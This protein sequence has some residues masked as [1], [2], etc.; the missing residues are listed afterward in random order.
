MYKAEFSIRVR[1]SETDRM[2][3]VYYGKYAEYFEVARVECLRS[4]GI[5]YKELEEDGVL[6]PVR[7]YKIRFFKPGFYDDV[8]R[9]ETIIPELPTAKILFTYKCF[10]SAHELLNEAETTLVFVNVKTNKPCAAPTEVLEKLKNYFN[11]D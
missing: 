7:D 4:L 8:I 9:I 11:V 5:T 1:Y 2:Q 6:L 3:Y 10:N